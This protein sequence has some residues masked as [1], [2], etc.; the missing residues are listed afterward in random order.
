MPL[1]SAFARTGTLNSRIRCERLRRE[2]L[3]CWYTC[4]VCVRLASS[5]KAI[6][7]VCLRS[8]CGPNMVSACQSWLAYCMLKAKRRLFS[9][10]SSLSI[11]YCLKV[12]PHPVARYT[13]QTYRWHFS[14]CCGF[15]GPFLLAGCVTKYGF[16]KREAL[17]IVSRSGSHKP[18][19]TIN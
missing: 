6:S 8:T 1:E 7:L 5:I 9:P 11:S 12:F 16:Q 14:N 18:T 17:Y 15:A 10:G 3:P 13:Q 19:Q 4:A 2:S